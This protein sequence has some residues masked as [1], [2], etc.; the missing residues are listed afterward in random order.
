MVGSSLIKTLAK[1]IGFSDC[2]TAQADR[3]TEEEYPLDAWL[4]EG[5]NAEMAYM[6]RNRG[7][8]RDPRLLVE[9]APH[10]LSILH[11]PELAGKRL[12]GFFGKY[13]T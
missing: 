4:A 3:L 9:G 13:F 12:Q 11:N 5:C 1:E 8:R 6:E 2:G 7:M 10:T